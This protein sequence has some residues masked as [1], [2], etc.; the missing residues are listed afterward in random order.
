MIVTTEVDFFFFDSRCG[1]HVG[2]E[3]VCSDVLP[4]IRHN[5]VSKYQL[6]LLFILKI[7]TVP[8]P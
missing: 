3:K 8:T 4:A 5:C 6:V 2:I 1:L 7:L